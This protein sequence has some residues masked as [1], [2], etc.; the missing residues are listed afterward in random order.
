MQQ[1]RRTR[2]GAALDSTDGH[3]HTAC[4]RPTPWPLALPLRVNCTRWYCLGPM[5]THCHG[6]GNPS[7]R[8][9]SGEE[10][11]R[12]LWCT[13]TRTSTSQ[14]YRA[15]HRSV[16][17]KQRRASR[18]EPAWFRRRWHCGFETSLISAFGS[19]CV[20]SCCAC[21]QGVT[22]AS[23]HGA[24]CPHTRTCKPQLPLS[25]PPPRTKQTARHMQPWR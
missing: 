4:P 7:H 24:T 12:P 11:Q 10:E 13:P 8:A 1:R 19:R 3:R 21:R 22:N 16:R 5:T 17:G 2:Q 20:G 14:T 25:R 6:H 9:E 18:S 23:M 15:N